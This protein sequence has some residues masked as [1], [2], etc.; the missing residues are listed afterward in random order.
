MHYFRCDSKSASP[1]IP[2]ATIFRGTC[3]YRC[4]SIYGSTSICAGTRISRASLYTGAELYGAKDRVSVHRSRKWD[5]VGKL[6][7]LR[8]S[9]WSTRLL[10]WRPFFRCF[11]RR[12]V[13][14]PVKRW[15]DDVE[16]LAGGNRAS[17]ATQKNLSAALREGFVMSL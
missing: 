6:A 17:I 7:N 11:P 14:H 13:G 4:T 1:L 15:E 12:S 16:V 9:W 8:D 3:I 10:A 2:T 5:F